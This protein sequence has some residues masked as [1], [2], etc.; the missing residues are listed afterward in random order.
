L[1][2]AYASN[3]EGEVVGAGVS[4]CPTTGIIESAAE[5]TPKTRFLP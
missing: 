1:F 3:C 4:S 2:V 5:K